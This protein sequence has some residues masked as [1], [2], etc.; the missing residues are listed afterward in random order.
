ITD[1]FV[2]IPDSASTNLGNIATWLFRIKF[3]S[4]AEALPHIIS[5]WIDGEANGYYI[6]MNATHGLIYTT[7]SGG[8][9]FQTYGNALPVLGTWYQYIVV[10]NGTAVTMYRNGALLPNA[11]TASHPTIATNAVST[12]FGKYATAFLNGCLSEV[13]IWKRGLLT[14]ESATLSA[15]PWSLY[16]PTQRRV[17]GKYILFPP[18][19]PALSSPLNDVINVV[20]NPTLYWNASAGATSY[21]LQVSRNSGF[22]DLFLDQSGVTDLFYAVSGL[23]NNTIYWWRV[24]A[25]NLA[26]AGGWSTE[27]HFT[28][29]ALPPPPIEA[30]FPKI[31]YNSILIGAVLSATDTAT[32]FDVQN[33][34]DYRPYTWWQ[35]ASIG[36]KYITI[37]CGVAKSA[38]CLGI[39]GHNLSSTNDTVSL[40]SSTDGITYTERITGFVPTSDKAIM[41]K[42]TSAS[43]RYWRI[44][45]IAPSVAPKLAVAFLG[46]SLNF[47]YPPDVPY[48]P[49]KETVEADVAEG[50]KGHL[51]G[52][53]LKFKS[54]NIDANFSNLERA[55]TINEFKLFWDNHGSKLLSFFYGWD[56]VNYPDWAFYV[57]C[58]DMDFGLPMSVLLYIDSISLRMKGVSEF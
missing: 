45:I 26:G 29:I 44:K 23:L 1:D 18:A 2:N 53:S 20:V 38:D 3:N 17:Y 28:T 27:W 25:S 13:L 46:V 24:N 33:I 9:H 7:V 8:T 50:K 15:D 41:K 56:L 21:R 54:L 6:Y 39:V 43:A 35:A 42:F 37:D 58:E 49:Y 36:T 51:L 12:M 48:I 31:L 47:P 55:W 14:R 22:T 57:N 19:P 10:K 32:D 52:A 34:K 4:I 16:R 5:K 40:E 30:S 11:T